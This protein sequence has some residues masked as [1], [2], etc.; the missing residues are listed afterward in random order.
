M[1]VFYSI[2]YDP[3]TNI[4]YNTAAGTNSLKMALNIY[5]KWVVI[6]LVM[7][8]F[9]IFYTFYPLYPFTKYDA[10]HF[11]T[12]KMSSYQIDNLLKNDFSTMFTLKCF[13]G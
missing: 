13:N 12:V 5:S 6:L 10:L 7:R 9:D 4:N 2:F 11:Y 3:S 1:I 8:A